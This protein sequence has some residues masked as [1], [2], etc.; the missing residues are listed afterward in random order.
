MTQEE[1]VNAIWELPMST[2][3][4]LLTM[5][6]LVLNP[7]PIKAAGVML[8]FL[9]RLAELQPSL[10]DRAEIAAL[11]HETAARIRPMRLVN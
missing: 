2:R 9:E 3:L 5:A 4:P 11:A 1:A 7:E 10:A 8:N 6:V